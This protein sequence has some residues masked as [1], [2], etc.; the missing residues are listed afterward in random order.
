MPSYQNNHLLNRQI[1]MLG[2]FTEPVNIP[3]AT[4]KVL[5][6]APFFVLLESLSPAGV[7]NLYMPVMS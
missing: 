7:Q 2:I 1:V 6:T 3:E 5:M 4:T